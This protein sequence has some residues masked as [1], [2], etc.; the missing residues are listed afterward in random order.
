MFHTQ[1][2]Q[3]NHQTRVNIPA[4]WLPFIISLV[5]YNGSV[6]NYF[7]WG[8]SHFSR[9]SSKNSSADCTI[10]AV[11]KEQIPDRKFAMSKLQFENF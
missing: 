9:G 1:P 10:C 2:V 7:S 6:F 3:S 4:S 8:P 11:K 5:S